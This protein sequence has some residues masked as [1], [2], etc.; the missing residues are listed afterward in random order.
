MEANNFPF[1]PNLLALL[2][3]IHVLASNKVHLLS[4]KFLKFVSTRLFEFVEVE[5]RQIAN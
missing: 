3:I 1:I 5:T 4:S 2:A